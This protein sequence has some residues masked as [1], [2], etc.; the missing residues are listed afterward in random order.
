MAYDAALCVTDAP[1]AFGDESEDHCSLRMLEGEAT[2]WY[3]CT[4]AMDGT[5]TGQ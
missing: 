3:S 2:R 4:V 5:G 1:L